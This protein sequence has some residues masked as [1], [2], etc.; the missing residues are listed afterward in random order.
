MRLGFKLITERKIILNI[1][2]YA[3]KACIASIQV[4]NSS[5][6]HRV[7]GKKH[8]FYIIGSRKF[9]THLYLKIYSFTF[10]KGI[11]EEDIYDKNIK[12]RHKNKF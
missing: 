12:L 11:I 5:H 1:V 3:I 10:P 9:K 4:L 2:Y 8:F 6:H 7:D